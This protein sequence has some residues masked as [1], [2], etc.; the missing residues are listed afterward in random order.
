[1]P[2]NDHALYQIAIKALLS[3][4][5]KFFVLI[6]TGGYLDFPGGRVDESERNIPWT[7]ALE[8]EI[9][10]EL[11]ESIVIEVGPTLFVSKRQYHKAGK[12]HHI[13]A[14]FFEC[15]Y[16]SGAIRL[17]DEHTNYEWLTPEEIMDHQQEFLSED[18]RDQLAVYF[19]QNKLR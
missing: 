7:K 18:E 15:K 12:M 9:A 17:S 13:A 1:M 10:E 14:I 3:N 11:G 16:I 6:T 5:D 2:L 19:D 8:R 4:E